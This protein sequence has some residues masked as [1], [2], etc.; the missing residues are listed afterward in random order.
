MKPPKR[1]KKPLNNKA[2]VQELR[3]AVKMAAFAVDPNYGRVTILA[4]KAGH[5]VYGINAAIQL[6]RFSAGM[7]C[8]L[9]IAVGRQHLTKE[10]L[11]PEKFN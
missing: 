1:K 4:K 3:K 6:G 2:R 8:A 5:T 9:E 11:C 10:F 7:A